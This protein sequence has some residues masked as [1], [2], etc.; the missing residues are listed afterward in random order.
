MMSLDHPTQSISSHESLYRDGTE[1]LRQ[2][3]AR[4]RQRHILAVEAM[5]KPAEPVYVAR[6]A[7][8]AAGRVLLGSTVMLLVVGLALLLLST[9]AQPG[10]QIDP[11][12]GSALTAVLLASWPAAGLAYA[13]ARRRARRNFVQ[14]LL[15]PI[16]V[17][18]DVH[19]DLERARRYDPGQHAM[20][21]LASMESASL[22]PLLAGIGLLLP[23]S[24]HFL[25]GMSLLGVELADFDGWIAMSAV[26]VGHCH[27]ILAVR[28]WRYGKQL[29]TAPTVALLHR[30]YEQGWKTYGIV[31]AASLFPGVLLLFVPVILVGVTGLFI[32]LLYGWAPRR[33]VEERD[34]LAMTTFRALSVV[35]E[36]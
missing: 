16:E 24:L 19:A 17:T 22:A 23:L 6:C 21:L 2:E 13:T 18:C 10:A 12:A 15:A 34:A 25:V 26:V 28:A 30:M 1:A 9:W 29:T 11:W 31:L 32:P 33:L 20:R 35:T 4:L 14:R 8:A 7:R 5:R 27:L 3:V 36:K